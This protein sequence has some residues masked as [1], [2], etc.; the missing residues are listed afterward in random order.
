MRLHPLPGDD[1][2]FCGPSAIAAIT[3]LHPKKEIR[4]VVNQIRY[5]PSHQGVCY[6]Q[7]QEVSDALR[8]LGV[9]CANPQKHP[10]KLTLQ[11]F[12][13]RHPAM[14]A[15]VEVAGHFIAISNGQALDSLSRIARPIAFFDGRRKRVKRYIQV[16]E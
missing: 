10:D 11:D 12:M 7:T 8:V 16:F 13:K 5:R 14:T 3:G 4:A 15:V 6:M 9:N 2:F 1:R